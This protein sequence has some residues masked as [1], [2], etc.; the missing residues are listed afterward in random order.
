[1]MVAGAT[2]RLRGAFAE[3]NA[4]RLG[5]LAEMAKAAFIG[6]R[7]GGLAGQRLAEHAVGEIEPTVAQELVRRGVEM[8]AKA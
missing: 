8:L 7:G 6:N 4:I 2:Q 1:M 3:A 5:E